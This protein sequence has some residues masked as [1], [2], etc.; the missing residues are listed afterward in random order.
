MEYSNEIRLRDRCCTIY[1][2]TVA[3]YLLRITIVRLKPKAIYII[4]FRS[5]AANTLIIGVEPKYV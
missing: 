3:Q 4:L 2:N 1:A 5:R